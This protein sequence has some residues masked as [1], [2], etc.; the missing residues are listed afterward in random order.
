MAALFAAC[1]EDH[2]APVNPDSA[3]P[4][5]VTAQAYSYDVQAGGTIWVGP[6]FAMGVTFLKEGEAGAE[7][8]APYAN[9]Q[10]LANGI[11]EEDYFVPAH[12]NEI[13]YF[14]ATGEKRHVAAYFPYSVKVIEQQLPINLR[15]EG[16]K[17]ASQLLFAREDN[18]DKD[19]RKCR[20]QMR[21][22]LSLITFRFQV[23]KPFTQEQLEAMKVTLKGFHLSGLFHITDGTVGFRAQDLP[24]G[25]IALAVPEKKKAEVRDAEEVYVL[26]AIALP[27]TETATYEAEVICNGHTYIQKFT[28][29]NITELK[30]G[31]EYIFEPTFKEDEMMLNCQSAPIINWKPGGDISGEGEEC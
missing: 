6:E 3:Y 30:G 4:V 28:D 24:D 19:H 23:G 10:Y 5:V 29:E 12:D 31:Y 15:E 7:V 9:V 16:K 1:D 17:F 27:S 14:P 26:Q 22:A 21:P 25:Q 18:M 20:L 8:V 11:S 2:K 13:P